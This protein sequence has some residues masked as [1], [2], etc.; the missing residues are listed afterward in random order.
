MNVVLFGAKSSPSTAI[1]IKNKNARFFSSKYPDS[2][3]KVINNCY[4]DDYLDS[5]KTAYEAQ[6]RVNEV[7]I[8]NKHAG[9][10]MHSW[11]SNAD[12]VLQDVRN[13]VAEKHENLFKDPQ[14]PEKVLGLRW[15]NTSDKLVFNVNFS[16]IPIELING[17]KKPTKREFL[18][19]IMYIFDLLG[20]LI[21]IT[22]QA[23]L[24]M[25]SVWSSGVKW[26]EVINQTEF[27]LWTKWL[28]EIERIKSVQINRCYQLLNSQLNEAELHVFCDASSKAYG[29]V[30]YWRFK[31]NENKYHVFFIVAK[32]RV[33]PMRG[34]ST[35]PRLEFQAAL[36]S[37]RLA[38]FIEKEH[39]FKIT[40]RIFWSD[41]EIVLHWINKD[42]GQ[43]KAFVANR[44]HEIRE[45]T[46]PSEWR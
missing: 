42:P 29:A 24:I 13:N 3:N 15:L 30:A 21:P 38:E 1:F 5:C 34:N 44:L 37:S 35:I 43:F 46:Q 39:E 6:K 33:V 36:I 20:F 8:I 4:M 9:F 27:I 25:Q 26:D 41:S 11:A 2:Y 40:R 31:L 19:L 17:N 16:K 45:K 12:V 22:I 28:Q 32:N 14:K 7:E 23:R 18:A 10:P